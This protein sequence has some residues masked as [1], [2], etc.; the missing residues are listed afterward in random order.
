MPEKKIILVGGG[1]HCKVVID[2]IRSRGEYH[3]FGIIDSR[4]SGR[5]VSGVRVIGRDGD[6]PQI[7]KKDK[8]RYAFVAVGS[9]GDCTIRQEIAA[10][11]KRIGFNL[12]VISH[13]SASVSVETKIKEGTFLSAGTI[14]NPG[15]KIGANAIIN[16]AAVIEHDCQVGDYAHISPGA[17]LCGEVKVGNCSHVG[18]GATIIQGVSIGRHT[19][20]GAGSLVVNDFGDNIKAFGI[21]AK[22]VS[23]WK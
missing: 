5:P 23:R 18:A 10:R 3:I 4:I 12:A 19:L 2:A 13:L 8:I 21:P 1:G 16:T 17:I 7:F 14:V 9:I 6:L 22:K 15:A 20:I 11:L